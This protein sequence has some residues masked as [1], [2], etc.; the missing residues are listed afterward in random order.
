MFLEKKQIIYWPTI[1]KEAQKS[2]GLSDTV[3]QTF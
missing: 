2:D 1:E 3:F